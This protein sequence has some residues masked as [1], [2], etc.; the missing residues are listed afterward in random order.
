M[1]NVPDPSDYDEVIGQVVVFIDL[2]LYNEVDLSTMLILLKTLLA[3]YCFST[4]KTVSCLI[5][6][7]WKFQADTQDVRSCWFNS[8]SLTLTKYTEW[9]FRRC[10]RDL[11]IQFPL[12]LMPDFLFGSKNIFLKVDL[13][14]R[15]WQYPVHLKRVTVCI[16]LQLMLVKRL[17][18]SYS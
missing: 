11:D 18:F 7:R 10:Q 13:S 15:K 3:A 6:C 5:L 2:Q 14:F 17:T 9:D 8:Q 1:L 12:K 4:A 16:D